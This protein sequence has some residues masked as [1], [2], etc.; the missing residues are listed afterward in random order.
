MSDCSQIPASQLSNDRSSL[1][2]IVRPG[3]AMRTALVTCQSISSVSQSS[4]AASLWTVIQRRG[5]KPSGSHVIQFSRPWE[6]YKYGFGLPNG[7][8]WLGNENLHLL[9]SHSPYSLRVDLWDL[10]GNFSFNQFLGQG[11]PHH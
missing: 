9:T 6:D 11:H 4:A 7:D 8:H 3:K 2:R 10:Q 5:W 1:T